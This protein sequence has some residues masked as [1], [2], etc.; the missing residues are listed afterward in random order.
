ML[1]VIPTTD[2]DQSVVDFL[3]RIT[4]KNSWVKPLYWL[5]IHLAFIGNRIGVFGMMSLLQYVE[6]TGM[7]VEEVDK[8]TGPGCGPP[9]NR[10]PSV[11]ADVVGI[12]TL[13]HW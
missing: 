11:P 4:E 10:Q 3:D 8:L 9:P 1:E 6:K 7:T 12:D 13:A 2:T 5:K